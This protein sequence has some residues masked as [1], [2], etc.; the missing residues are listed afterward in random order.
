MRKLIYFQS[1]SFNFQAEGM[2]NNIGYPDFINN[3]T[4]LDEHYERVSSNFLYYSNYSN[5][6]LAYFAKIY[7]I[8]IKYLEKNSSKISIWITAWKPNYLIAPTSYSNLDL[9]SDAKFFFS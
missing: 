5:R 2:I 1:Y 6:Y 3:D 4:A 8:N 7:F 9:N